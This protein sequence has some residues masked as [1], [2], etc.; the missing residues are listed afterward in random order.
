MKQLKR[1]HTNKTS[2]ARS[3]ITTFHILFS[4]YSIN[5]LKCCIILRRI[6]LL[7]SLGGGFGS[8]LSL[9][10]SLPPPFPLSPFS[11][12]PFLRLLLRGGD[13]APGL[14]AAEAAAAPRSRVLPLLSTFALICLLLLPPPP[15][16]P[17]SSPPL[18][19]L[20]LLPGVP[21]GAKG[22]IVSHRE[23]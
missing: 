15:P 13:R 1:K 21:S 5:Y 6:A 19:L 18:L 11:P 10:P 16:P 9:P 7:S 17:L 14:T 12:P 3:S 2:N 8:S 4:F 23:P 22:T 20:L